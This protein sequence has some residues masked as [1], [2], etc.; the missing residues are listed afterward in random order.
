MCKALPVQSPGQKKKKKKGLGGWNIAQWYSACL[1]PR[2]KEKK[3]Q[4]KTKQNKNP[5]VRRPESNN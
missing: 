4:N 3:R 1:V 2:K 5:I